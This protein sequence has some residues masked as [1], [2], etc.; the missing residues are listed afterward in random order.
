MIWNRTIQSLVVTS[1]LAK[2]QVKS[3][4][5]T[6]ELPVVNRGSKFFK[7][8]AIA[9]AALGWMEQANAIQAPSNGVAGDAGNKLV[10]VGGG[11][12]EETG[13][14]AI[15]NGSKAKGGAVAI[16]RDSNAP[17]SNS[18]AHGIA[19]TASG[20]KAIAIGSDAKSNSKFCYCN[21]S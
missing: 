2:G 21:G 10:A 15:G 12:A 4:S 14:I 3:S 18:V 16:G 20:I 11:I 1:E 9:L 17:G 13:A 19:T 5:D 8:S 7:L 6:S